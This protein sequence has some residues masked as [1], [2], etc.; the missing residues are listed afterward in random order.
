MSVHEHGG[1]DYWEQQAAGYALD[2]LEPEEAAEFVGHLSD[3]SQ[4][5]A[6]VDQHALVAAQ[7]GALAYDDRPAPTWAELRK[8]VVET[9]DRP[10][11]NVVPIRRRRRAVLVS[12]AAASVAA[13]VAIAIWQTPNGSGNGPLTSASAC[14][15]TSG[16][17]VVALRA[18]GK[19][20]LSVLVYGRDVAL[21]STAMA[22]PPPGSEWALWRL[23]K[24]GTPQ[25]MTTFAKTNGTRAPLGLPYAD[26][27]G[28]AVSREPNGTAP[29]APS[30]VVATGTI[31]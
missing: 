10:A 22:P 2:A 24:S 13:V 25:L 31:A 16:C 5:Q 26:I 19:T 14:A 23:P 21:A 6:L 30:V 20:A 8:G 9:P 7:L 3:C 4:C 1:H 29:A 18:D 17:H 11:N 12:A 27:A 28:F 15:A